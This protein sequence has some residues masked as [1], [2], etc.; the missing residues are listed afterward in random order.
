MA[1]IAV[2]RHRE[3]SVEYAAFI[4]DTWCLGVKEA[5]AVTDLPADELSE[6]LAAWLPERRRESIDP[7]CARKLIE[8]AVAYA[9]ELGFA[10]HHD[11]RKAR[12]VLSG[13]DAELCPTEFSYGRNGK[14][15]YV[16]GIESDEAATRVIA[17]LKALL[18]E[19]GFDHELAPEFGVGGEDDDDDD[20]GDDVR[21]VRQELIDF[22][23]AEPASVP[24][25]YALSGML[26][27]ALLSPQPVPPLTVLDLLWGPT[28][29]MWASK[30][31]VEVFTDNLMMY[32]NHLAGVVMDA[33]DVDDPEESPIVDVWDEDCPEGF[34]ND[35]FVVGAMIEWSGGFLRA[36]EAW[37]DRWGKALQQPELAEPLSL[38]RAYAE[39]LGPGNKDRIAT[40]IEAGESLDQAVLAIAH[41][42]RPELG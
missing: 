35:K 31:D 34:D 16:Q 2:V 28:G 40:A 5:T 11:Y 37:P 38:I 22:L 29:K 14:P 23:E 18:G 6:V 30:D 1:Q 19:D 17:R 10:P 24:R 42:A 32:W 26:T 27:A 13:L 25:F 15:F 3:G 20:N 21:E 12:R 33:C 39:S 8:G 7:H 41:A 36:L 9:E 4:V